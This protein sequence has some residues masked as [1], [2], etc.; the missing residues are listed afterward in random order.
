M[1]DGLDGGTLA[2]PELADLGVTHSVRGYQPMNVSH[3]QAPW[4]PGHVGLP[5]PTYPCRY[6]GFRWDRD[7]LRDLYRPWRS[8]EAMGVPVHVGEFGCYDKM[9]DDVARA[10]FADLFAVFAEFGW[11]YALWEF[12]GPFGLVGHARPGAVF[13]QLDGFR[14][15]RNLLDLMRSSRA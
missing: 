6:D 13:E 15:D 14:V 2:M 3:Y 9:P 11:G 4:W 12:E 10:W 8:V 1:I 7:G 5:Q